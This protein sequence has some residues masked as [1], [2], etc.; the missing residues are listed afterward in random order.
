MIYP[1]FEIDLPAEIEKL[2]QPL[3]CEMEEMDEDL[4]LDE[5]VEASCR[6]YD[7]LSLPQ[8]NVLLNY[9]KKPKKTRFG[10]GP[11]F[12]VSFLFYTL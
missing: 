11:T 7:S 6:L 4:D 9:K 3:F 1:N 12:R 5:F 10:D 2:F 8:K